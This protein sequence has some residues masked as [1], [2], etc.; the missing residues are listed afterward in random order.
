VFKMPLTKSGAACTFWDA[1]EMRA[2]SSGRRATRASMRDGREF[3]E[4]SLSNAFTSDGGTG[5]ANSAVGMVAAPMFP[6]SEAAREKEGD[7][8]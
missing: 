5:L 7:K 3:V 1:L 4:V 6:R 8:R 2:R